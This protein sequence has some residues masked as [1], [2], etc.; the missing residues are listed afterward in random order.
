MQSIINTIH[1]FKQKLVALVTAMG[2]ILISTNS[3]LAFQD[4]GTIRIGMLETITGGAAPYGL[5]GARGTLLA[6][7]EVNAEGG[8]EIGG[9][10]VKIVVVGGGELGSDGGLDPA[11]AIAG[12]KKL[13]LDEHV[14]MVKGPTTSTNSEAIFNYLNELSTQG[15]GLVVH[16]SSAGA[17]GL[18]EISKWGFRNSFAESYALSFLVENM[19]KHTNAKTAAIYHLTDNPYFPAMAELM[20]KELSKV[21]VEVK[22][23][24]TGL[25]KDAEFSRQVKEIKSTNPDIVYLSA[26]NLRGIGFMKEAFRRRLQPSVFIGGISQLV[27]DTINSGGEAAEGM[28]MIGS[29]DDNGPGI[30]AYREKFK[31]R[32]NEDINLFSVNGYE[33]GQLLIKALQ[34]SGISNTKDSLQ[35]DREKLRVAYESVSIDSISGYSVGFNAA[36]DTPKSGVIL[37]IKDGAFQAWESH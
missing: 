15:S 5:A 10:K 7:E 13:V 14:L 20:T 12:L 1:Q 25:S 24:A 34:E 27:P 31:A 19:V 6:I 9:K 17:P 4:E 18:G 37:T 32:W 21:G 33:A 11:L 30:S 23:T 8:I 16:S 26:D 22:A 35:G 3:I 36:H 2:L 29:Y 28:V